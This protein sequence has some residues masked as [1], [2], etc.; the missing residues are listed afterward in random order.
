MGRSAPMLIR[1][2]LAVL[3]VTFLATGAFALDVS[4]LLSTVA[5]PLAV[6]AA[7]E[8]PGVQQNDLIDLVAQLNTANVPPAEFVQIVR[9][10][11]VALID[12][13]GQPQIVQ[14]V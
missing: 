9:Y 10:V 12:Q 14:Y 4:N 13:K 3:V 6:A 1:R 2:F 5:M 8:V 11:P 7:S